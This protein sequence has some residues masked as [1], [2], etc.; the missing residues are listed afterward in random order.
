MLIAR[1]WFVECFNQFTI[2]PRTGMLKSADRV[3]SSEQR[4]SY[5]T[6][7]LSIFPWSLREHM[8]SLSQKPADL[9]LSF[10]H[11][12]LPW[13][14]KSYCEIFQFLRHPAYYR[15]ER[16]QARVSWFLGRTNR[17]LTSRGRE[18]HRRL[19]KRSCEPLMFT[20]KAMSTT[21]LRLVQ[22]PTLRFNQKFI[23]RTK[24]SRRK[25][26]ELSSRVGGQMSTQSGERTMLLVD[27]YNYMSNLP[28]YHIFAILSVGYLFYYLI[29]VVKVR[30]N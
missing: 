2:N 23:F 19:I 22:S 24:V 13:I 4:F 21:L 25:A 15:R 8:T 26:S 11:A 1:S 16:V 20:R 17:T 29:E 3:F 10:P 28:R 9:L 27:L 30:I 7:W 18:A 12:P 14:I 6:I 5:L